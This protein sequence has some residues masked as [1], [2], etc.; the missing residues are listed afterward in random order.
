MPETEHRKVRTEDGKL[1]FSG[2]R[3]FNYYDMLPGVIGPIDSEGWF[4]FKHDARTSSATLNGE[5]ICTIEFAQA[6]GWM[7][8]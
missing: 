3:A 2:D 4:D 6:Q 7:S 1:L 5:R 8:S